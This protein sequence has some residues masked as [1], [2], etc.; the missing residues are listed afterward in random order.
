MNIQNID[1]NKLKPYSKNP[2]RN[3]SAIKEV[4]ESISQ[5]GFNQPIVCDQYFTICV[6]HTRWLAAKE[7]GITEVPVLVKEMNQKQFKAYNL[8]DNKTHQ[9][10]EWD[11]ELL[12]DMFQEDDFY[13]DEYTGFND[14]EIDKLLTSVDA[15][16]NEIEDKI[17]EE[18][19]KKY[20]LEIEFPD[21]QALKDEYANLSSQGL[22]VRIK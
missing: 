1:I 8:A 14:E 18:K 13:L 21:E 16:D 12:K 5:H 17:S 11:E 9:F 6:G 7:L 19:E 22:I 4:V 20:L 15:F 3:E 2:R 10:S